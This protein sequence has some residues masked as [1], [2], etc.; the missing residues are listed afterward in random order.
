LAPGRDNL[1]DFEADQMSREM[2]H[3]V[4]QCARAN[5]DLN[6]T[7]LVE[8]QAIALVSRGSN[9]IILKIDL[10]PKKNVFCRITDVVQMYEYTKINGSVKAWDD[11][12]SHTS[13]VR[14]PQNALGE[15]SRRMNAAVTAYKRHRGEF[16]QAHNF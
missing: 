9:K 6:L 7:T 14:L 5:R 3:E 12:K 1:D 2:Q 15:L 10:L 11:D 13:T 8:R 4:D 16:D